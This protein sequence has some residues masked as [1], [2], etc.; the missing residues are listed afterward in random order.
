MT[1]GGGATLIGSVGVSLLLLA[2]LLNLFGLLRA[3]GY[4]YLALN[5]I[6]GALACFSS[7]LIGFAPFVVLEGTWAAVAGFGL[8]RKISG[9]GEPQGVLP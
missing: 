1:H 8:V 7:Y 2:F 9:R 3:G 5:F 4:A 6:G